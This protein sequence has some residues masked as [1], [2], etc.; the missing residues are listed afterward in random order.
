MERED[1]LLVWRFLAHET[2]PCRSDVIFT[3]GSGSPHVARRSGALY[4]EGR[5]PWILVTG[6]ATGQFGPA[7]TEAD[8]HS[9]ILQAGG[10]PSER[11]I[12]ER[13]ASNTGENVAFGMSELAARGI[14]VRS[15][16]LVAFPTSLRRCAATF[17]WQNPLVGLSAQPAFR[18]LGPYGSVPERAVDAV[19]A[20]VERLRTYPVLGHIAPYALPDWVSDA[21]ERLRSS[22]LAL[23]STLAR[24]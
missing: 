16:V 1:L 15:A 13:R 11:V 14:K 22:T 4:A 7:E 10:V 18:D 21:A 23:P 8:A 19:L 17:A 5:A 20:E 12:V 24:T 3:F 9:R 6:G 2:T